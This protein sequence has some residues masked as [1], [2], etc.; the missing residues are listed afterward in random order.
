MDETKTG[1]FRWISRNAQ[2]GFWT[3]WGAGLGAFGAVFFRVV[4]TGGDALRV[5]M[6]ILTVLMGGALGLVS[7]RAMD[8]HSDKRARRRKMLSVL[9]LV[10]DL[11]WE[12]N[13]L[14]QEVRQ[15]I[16]N[17]RVI[18]SMGSNL[19]RDECTKVLVG[20]DRVTRSAACVPSFDD[21]ADDFEDVEIAR[22][23]RSQFVFSKDFFS[24]HPQSLR[25]DVSTAQR[26][27]VTIV[28]FNAAIHRV[29]SLDRIDAHLS[30]KI[31]NL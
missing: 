2:Y 4:D 22:L 30:G 15:I 16:A 19:T 10:R 25:G 6:G 21:L 14:S 28:N 17:G 23:C 27:A 8:Q 1:W 24:V 3:I 26:R 29:E 9:V 20:A 18:D 13:S 11:R 12:L 5:Y 7:S 31:Q